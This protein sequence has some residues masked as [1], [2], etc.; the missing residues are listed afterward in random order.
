[1]NPMAKFFRSMGGV[2]LLLQL[3]LFFLPCLAVRQENYPDE[4]YSPFRFAK[5]AFVEVAGGEVSQKTVLVGVVIVLPVVLSL[6]MGI[7]GIVGGSKQRVSCVFSVILLGFNGAFCYLLPQL[8]P[9]PLNAEQYFP[10]EYGFWG[11]LAVGAVVAICGIAG[12]VATPRKQ[13]TKGETAPFLQPSHQN[14]IPKI[15]AGSGA[16]R[17]VMEGLSGVYKGAKIPFGPGET[18]KLGRDITN[19]LVF[20]GCDKVSRFHCAITWYPELKKFQITDQSVNGCFVNGSEE[21]LP[22]N[23][24][25]DLEPG[26]MLAIGDQDN[27][28][29]MG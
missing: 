8:Q 16:P 10:K 21:R 29:R 9:E 22:Q 15:S 25:V 3:V 23:T 1:M 4:Q 26:T 19:D 12:I 27:V 18:I 14:P 13:E 28:F 20:E 6:V 7:V 11:I 5:E 24:T 2:C 17:G